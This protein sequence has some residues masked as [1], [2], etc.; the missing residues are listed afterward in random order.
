MLALPCQGSSE[1]WPLRGVCAAP[2]KS[3]LLLK[4]NW[5]NQ[6]RLFG[7]CSAEHSARWEPGMDPGRAK[8]RK[9]EP[10]ERRGGYRDGVG[11]SRREMTARGGRRDLV[12]REG[13][14]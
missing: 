13:R 7:L 11:K 10:S 3:K 14:R 2:S 5:L 6:V 12:P 8:M 1:A 9:S 4:P